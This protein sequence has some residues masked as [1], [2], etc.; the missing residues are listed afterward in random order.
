MLILGLGGKAGSGKTT[1]ARFLA[2]YGFKEIAFADSLKESASL[3]FGFNQEQTNGF[4]KE[5]ID[6]RLG[7]SPRMVMQQF[8]DACRQ[9][10]PEVFVSA[11]RRKLFGPY[12]RVVVSDI[13]FFNEAEALSRLGAM[14]VR[15]ERPG[16]GA[17]N[18]I[19]SHASEYELDAW[20]GWSSVIVNSGCSR[21]L[22]YRQIGYLLQ[23]WGVEPLV[24]TE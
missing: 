12:D 15:I 7:K 24:E 20:D 19:E 17:Q 22:F 18:G 13:R 21:E 16:A 4:L 14:L 5:V 10:W 11:V 8:G 3:L 1:A 2:S 23:R 6:P 9:I